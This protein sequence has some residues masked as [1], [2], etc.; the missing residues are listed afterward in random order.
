MQRK[1][2]VSAHLVCLAEIV[3]VHGV[4]GIVKIKV[5]CD[6][7]DDLPGYAPLCDATEKREFR[8]ASFQPHQNI[9]LAEIEG[10]SDRT[11]A[12]KLRGTRLYV[13]RDRLPHIEDDSTYYH[14]DL[15]GLAVKDADGTTLGT[16][17]KVENFGAGDLL[18]I[19]PPKGASYYLPFTNANVPKVDIARKEV[20][21]VIPPGLLD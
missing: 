8:F 13:P 17:L 11:Q 6:N 3:G 1:E 12:E 21:V 18:E 20:T 4:R 15:V 2:D 10:L 5:F 9:W 14:V 16:V 19:K 7:P